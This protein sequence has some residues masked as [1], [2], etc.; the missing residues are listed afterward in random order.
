M[1]IEPNEVSTI[2]I[3]V[4]KTEPKGFFLDTRDS[5]KHKFNKDSFHQDAESLC[6][7]I[8]TLLKP[9]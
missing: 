7:R 5:L 3:T 9:I 1:N 4:S 6:E 8:K 2:K